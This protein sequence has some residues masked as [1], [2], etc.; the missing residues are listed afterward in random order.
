MSKSTSVQYGNGHI[1]FVKYR[2]WGFVYIYAHKEK[3]TSKTAKHNLKMYSLYEMMIV[4]FIH[5]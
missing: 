1:K 5:K 3:V 2:E 4:I